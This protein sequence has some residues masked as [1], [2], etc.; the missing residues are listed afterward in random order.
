M[1]VKKI[2]LLKYVIS[3]ENSKFD[4]DM[5]LHAINECEDGTEIIF[6]P[7]NYYF[8]SPENVV[9][10]ENI[11]KNIIFKA[12]DG[13]RFIGGKSIAGAIPVSGDVKSRFF[14]EIRDK[15]FC[16]DLQKNGLILAD[17]SGFVLRGFACGVNPSHSEIFADGIPL[18]LSCYPKDDYLNITGYGEEILKIYWVHEKVGKFEKGFYYDCERPEKWADSEE[19]LAHGYWSV[20]YA[21]S[22]EKIAAI[23]K[24]SRKITLKEPYGGHEFRIGQRFSFHNILE[25]VTECGDYYID[26]KDMML[27]FI[28]FD[29]E[30]LPEEILISTLKEPLWNID[31]CENLCFEGFSIEAACGNGITVLNSKNIKISDG[32]ST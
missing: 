30:K 25:E 18:N 20:D 10:L 24:K 4:A 6:E 19:I 23:D 22:Y 17:V 1:K 21:N 2:S 14:P 31:K 3:S 8:P 26:R 16:V 5:L 11:T 15:I 13:A 29:F 9:K 27:Y 7:G 32:K 28:P 12:M